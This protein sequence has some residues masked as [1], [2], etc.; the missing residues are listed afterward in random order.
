MR[1]LT[2]EG[3]GPVV[4]YRCRLSEP[5][6]EM[7]PNTGA[8][9][10]TTHEDG[11]GF[12]GAVGGGTDTYHLPDGATISALS[13]DPGPTDVNLRVDGRETTADA[14]RAA[15]PTDGTDDTDTSEG[16]DST[17]GDGEET[18]DDTGDTADP[19]QT[20]RDLAE[21]LHAALT[22]EQCMPVV[23]GIRET[24]DQLEKLHGETH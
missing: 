12:E 5:G 24:A 21:T 9:P 18:G 13:F 6:V 17:G 7:G 19:T 22:D 16:S 23:A 8:G 1:T 15:D 3:T 2:I 10:D 14:L 20:P 4:S 11:M